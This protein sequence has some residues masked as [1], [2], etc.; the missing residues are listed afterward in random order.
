MDMDYGMQE[1]PRDYTKLVWASVAVMLVLMVL[2]IWWSG[3]PSPD[4]SLV[5]TRHIL[6]SFN[7]QDQA[8]RRRAYTLAR[9]LRE[10]ILAGESFAALARDYS[11]D[12]Q[13]SSRGGKL[14]PFSKRDQLESQF[15]DFAWNAPAGTLSDIL[16]TSYGYHLVIVDERHLS[17]SDRYA[18][19]L[20]RRATE[21]AGGSRGVTQ[22]EP[23]TV[24]LPP[25]P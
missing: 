20:Q 19:E 7:P 6:V 10:R 13:S 16:T 21:G 15:S 25:A 12:D 9:E 2:G 22:P 1:E 24:A 17:Q 11:N 14:P 8:D 23:N 5:Y 4:E 18:E 3:R